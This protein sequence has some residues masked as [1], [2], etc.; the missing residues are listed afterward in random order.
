[1]SAVPYLLAL[2]T[3]NSRSNSGGGAGRLEALLSLT[4]LSATA[5][6]LWSLPA[7]VTG[8]KVLDAWVAGGDSGNNKGA[9]EAKRRREEEDDSNRDI[10]TAPFWTEEHRR[11]PLEKYLPY[12]NAGLCGILVLAGFIP[13]AVGSQDGRWDQR[14][15]HV[16]LSNLPAIVYGVV[17]AAKVVMGGVDPERELSALRYEYKGA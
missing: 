12:L 6:T 15:G 2:V 9:K 4:S 13:K 7:G 5:W 8:I 14:W 1:M 16:A 3:P 10:R 17:L 11:S